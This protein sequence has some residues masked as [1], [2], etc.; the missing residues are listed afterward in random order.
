MVSANARLIAL[1]PIA[2]VGAGPS[3][4]STGPGSSPVYATSLSTPSRPF[5]RAGLTDFLRKPLWK[6]GGDS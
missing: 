6:R 2:A 4:P 5:Q 1:V 3:F